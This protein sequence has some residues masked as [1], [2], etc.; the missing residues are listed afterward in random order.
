MKK[1]IL[2]LILAGIACVGTL[3]AQIECNENYS[4]VLDENGKTEVLISDLV[5]NIEFM[6]TQ[7]T[8]TY[9]FFP[10][11]TG[12]VSSAD[13]IIQ[14]SCENRGFP[15]YII[16]VTS[17]GDLIEN[18]SGQLVITSPNGGCE[19]DNPGICGEEPDCLKIVNGYVLYSGDIDIF[20]VDIALCEDALGCDGTYSIAYGLASDGPSLTFGN[21]ISSADATAYENPIT[22]FYTDA[23]TTVFLQSYVYIWENAECILKANYKTLYELDL[24]AE[25][26]ITPENLI[27]EAELCGPIV[28]AMT[29]LDGA[30]PDDFEDFI[31]VD[32]DDIGEKR[33]WVRNPETGFTLSRVVQILDPLEACG[34]VLGPGDR[35]VNYTDGIQ[36]LFFNTNVDLN[37]SQLPKHP[38]GI[39]WIIDEDDLIEGENII[40]FNF[41]EFS[42][43]GISTL[44]LVLGLRIILND[45]YDDPR[46]SVLFDIDESGYNGLGDAIAMREIILGMNDG[47][48]Y[49][50]AYFFNNS[51]VFPSDFDPF[52]FENTFTQYAFDKADF[53]TT[54]LSFTAR[55]VGD[56][57]QTAVP[58]L[59]EKQDDA[60]FRSSAPS[61]L[62][63][64]M[65]VEAG[66]TFTFD[67]TYESE[68][69][70]KGL[71]AA[72]VGDGIEFLELIDPAA[73][74]QSNIIDENEIRISYL[75]Q[76]AAAEI[77][78][79][80]FKIRATTT[81]S[82]ELVE[83]LGLK[84]G[85]PQEVVN[86]N[87]EVIVIDEISIMTTSSVNISGVSANVSIFPNP[88]H[89]YITISTEH[90]ALESVSIIDA[91]GRLVLTEKLSNTN[92]VLNI[93]NLANGLY[94]MTITTEGGLEAITFVKE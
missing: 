43:N 9:Y 55:K 51:Y 19:G 64:D 30:E 53:M 80:S 4:T 14:L 73:G 41:D 88:A 83:L 22:I 49:S 71:L 8:V 17:G 65:I 32:C 90:V 11:T 85:F 87:N 15:A 84:S 76:F 82:G 3:T 69:K 77:D 48:E 94:H 89:N 56:L 21:S 61:Y 12:T 18:C 24:T 86:E 20:A 36:G 38:G 93:D 33:I 44:D 6:L 47:E 78:N 35:L 13:D 92:E 50:D 45:E 74:V 7:G 1:G 34:T 59:V 66:E 39:G 28:I 23:S 67:L 26:Q 37:G 72:L 40:N 68:V 63:D 62:V 70:F 60:T 91:L 29:E 31:N 79:I 42:L 27:L 54:D 25:T 5:S 46:T 10:F 81:K 52:D 57:N 75:Q 16:E 2:S 58:G